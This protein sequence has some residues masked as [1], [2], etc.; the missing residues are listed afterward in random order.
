MKITTWNV[1]SIKAR[2]PHV[3]AWL[4]ENDVDVLCLQE[5]KT[6]DEAFPLEPFQDAGYHVETFGQPTYNGVAFISKNPLTDIQK[7]V[8]HAELDIHARMIAGT[9][10]GV[11]V[12]NL[13][14]PNGQ[15]PEAPAFK[16]KEDW[17]AGVLK[18]LNEN[19]TPED[20]V[21]VCGDMNIAPT[22]VD[23]WDHDKVYGTVC[24]H[25]KE[26]EW[27]QMWFDWGLKDSFRELYPEEKQFSWWD[28]RRLRF[29][30]NEGLRIDLL[31]VT[32]PLMAKSSAVEID[33]NERKK[34]R[35][36]DHVPVT[37]TL[38]I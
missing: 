11:R 20:K 27:L 36:S 33:R 21:V 13:Y 34:E 9:Y 16:F 30:K 10:N 5:L 8:G 18:H 28:Y 14:M 25:P 38:D 17:Y 6:K 32:E 31:L 1:N 12:I 29:I 22:A 3:L 2:A 15:D 4:A 26:H 24:Y 35:P 23:V 19:F 7:G 37:L